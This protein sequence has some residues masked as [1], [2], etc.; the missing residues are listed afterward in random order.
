M[1]GRRDDNV[2][3]EQFSFMREHNVPSLLKQ[4]PKALDEWASKNVSGPPRLK[5]SRSSS[6]NS[7]LAD[8]GLSSNRTN[9]EAWV[10]RRIDE[11]YRELSREP[12]DDKFE[13]WSD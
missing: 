12:L 7:S 9:V 4:L 3:L 11:I 13:T 10:S 6:L 1:L 8:T 5:R 2:F